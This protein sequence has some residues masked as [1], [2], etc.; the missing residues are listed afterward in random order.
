LPKK[1]GNYTGRKRAEA[2]RTILLSRDTVKIRTTDLAKD[3]E[4]QLLMQI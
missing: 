1:V 2:S 4:T 3:I